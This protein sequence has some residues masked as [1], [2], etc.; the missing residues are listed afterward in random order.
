[1][2]RSSLYDSQ[3]SKEIFS[4]LPPSD[5]DLQR[6]ALEDSACVLLLPIVEEIIMTINEME[7]ISVQMTLE[8]HSNE[9]KEDITTIDFLPEQI[10]SD[11]FVPTEI[12]KL[13][14]LHALTWQ[15][16]NVKLVTHIESFQE[17][18]DLASFAFDPFYYGQTSKH[19]DLTQ[20]NVLYS[21][22]I[23]I[24]LPGEE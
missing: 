22:E 20:D 8:L 7:P 6:I 13:M 12:S 11:Q 2:S 18:E 21:F 5:E 24:H 1:M 10:F 14:A 17:E 3:I 4:F 19:F 23:V 16:E 15:Y 9:N